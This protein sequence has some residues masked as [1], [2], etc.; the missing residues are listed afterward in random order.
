MAA[1]SGDTALYFATLARS[2]DRLD[3]VMRTESEW[4]KRSNLVY[5][6]VESHLKRLRHSL[7]C[8][9]LWCRFGD[10]FKVDRAESGFPMFRHVL[11]AETDRTRREEYLLD[12]PKPQRIR[13]EM[14]EQILKYKQFPA[15][16]QATMAKRLYYDALGE[17]EVFESFTP[18]ELLRH[19]L[20]PRSE[21]PYYIVHWG[22]YDGAANLP[23]VYMAVIEDSSPNA[24]GPSKRK[25]RIWR[26][27][28]EADA[29][30]VHGL[31]NLSLL[32]PFREFC[33]NHSSYSL[34]LT[35]IATAMDKDFEHLHPKQLRRF[36]LGPFYAGGL[37]EHNEKVQSVLDTVSD[38]AEN[39][40][41]TW[42]AQELHSKEQVPAKKG[43][44]GGTP[45]KEVYYIN[46]DDL[47]CAQ[48]GVSAIERYALI[49]HAAYQATF[50]Q[51]RADEIFDDYKCYIAS[52]DTIIRHV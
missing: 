26:D 22:A 20:N 1:S 30:F 33:R 40:L 28:D 18:P 8:W 27:S 3:H 17:A 47:D 7:E 15:E 14:I 43:I 5:Q 19:S 52:G 45:A 41:L 29:F 16:L 35:S 36:V 38:T 46:T 4:V 9:Q 25:D 50:A 42:A 51:G 24:P 23:M 11:D 39:W 31:P 13:R 10:S 48:Q 12:M 44:W 34:T 49:P 37:T 2:F 6:A 32:K 21:R